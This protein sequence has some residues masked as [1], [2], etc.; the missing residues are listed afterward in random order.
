MP[1]QLFVE[2]RAFESICS[3]ERY[4]VGSDLDATSVFVNFDQGS[5]CELRTLECVEPRSYSITWG[6]GKMREHVRGLDEVL[7]AASFSLAAS[8]AASCAAHLDFSPSLRSLELRGLSFSTAPLLHILSLFLL[9][10]G[11]RCIS[12]HRAA[13][14]AVQ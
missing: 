7:F 6:P 12:S 2:H 11:P 3:A 1:R 5:T 13:H 8:R 14:E 10:K 4:Q 9:K